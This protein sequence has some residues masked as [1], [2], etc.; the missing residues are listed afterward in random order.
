MHC[1]SSAHSSS[2][3]R[4]TSQNEQISSSPWLSTCAASEDQT[5]FIE[6]SAT[7]SLGLGS[8]STSFDSNVALPF[9]GTLRSSSSVLS[10]STLS[11]SASI[12]Q[13]GTISASSTG[14]QPNLTPGA[15]YLARG[16]S[17]DAHFLL[18]AVSQHRDNDHHVH[19]LTRG[20]DCDYDIDSDNY[21]HII[22][23]DEISDST[24]VS[25]IT[26]TATTSTTLTITTVATTT[27]TGLGSTTVTSTAT[28]YYHL[29]GGPVS[30]RE[31][32]PIPVLEAGP[33]SEIGER[34]LSHALDPRQEIVVPPALALLESS[35][36]SS[37]CSCLH[38]VTPTA[39]SIVTASTQTITSTVETTSTTV[40]LSGVITTSLTTTTTTVT[41]SSS[42]TLTSSA[43]V[44]T[45]SITT[46][47]STTTRS[48]P[49]A[50][51]SEPPN[52][53]PFPYVTRPRSVLGRF[54]GGMRLD[55]C[56]LCYQ[57]P[58]CI[59]YAYFFGPGTCYSVLATDQL[60]TGV[61][62]YCPLG[63]SPVSQISTDTND[64]GFGGYQNGPCNIGAPL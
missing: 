9:G 63:V 2:Y 28:V 29:D 3:G 48:I 25:T 39:T 56:V 18:L 24:T 35:I 4:N 23:L 14:A 31:A 64:P 38:I 12:T 43:A 61:T 15:Q 5:S 7:A 34:A 41:V 49:A 1:K 57:E 58:N 13:S 45:T 26:Q 33:A 17:A 51:T 21:S 47:T 22:H 8:S 62:N 16:A 11:V 30:R 54:S 44:S 6:I 60:T 32:A 52:K 42:T 19:Y 40:T 37:V 53:Y 36:I 27:S 20:N 55:C 46:F 59:L 50:C 10:S